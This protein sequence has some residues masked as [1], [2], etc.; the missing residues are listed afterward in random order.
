MNTA[1]ALQ[2]GGDSAEQRWR[3]F[4]Q[5]C[6]CILFAIFSRLKVPWI[7]H[8]TRFVFWSIGTSKVWPT[9]SRNAAFRRLGQ[10]YLAVKLQRS[11]C[12]S[13]AGRCH[14]TFA[15]LRQAAPMNL[16]SRHDMT[17]H[18]MAW[19]DMTWRDN[20]V[21]WYDMIWYD[22]IWYDFGIH[23]TYGKVACSGDIQS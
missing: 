23:W 10:H 9:A 1:E 6:V 4:I 3:W 11:P 8:W 19:H 16:Y 22:M 20:D 17:W 12:G 7:S 5:N 14:S 2:S 21:I 13:Q 18:D 15:W